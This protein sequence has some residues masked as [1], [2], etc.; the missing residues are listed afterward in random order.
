MNQRTSKIYLNQNT[1]MLTHNTQ[2]ET[3]M[4]FKCVQALFFE[5][6]NWNFKKQ[7]Y[8]S[9]SETIKSFLDDNNIL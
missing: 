7:A 4:S 3:C 8:I 1:N 9:Y 2:I 6:G 5:I